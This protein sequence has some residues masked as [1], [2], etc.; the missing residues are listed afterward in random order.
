VQAALHIGDLLVYHEIRW[1]VEIVWKRSSA[2]SDTKQGRRQ[3]GRVHDLIFFYTKG[4][5]WTWNPLYTPYDQS[6]INAFYKHVEPETGRCYRLGD[7]TGP[8][9]AAKGN[10]KYEV[11]G[12]TRYWRYSKEKM[13]DL[14]R[15]GR[16]VQTSPGAVPAYKRY[17]DEMPGVPLQDV[18]T[19]IS[20][21]G[22]QAQERLGYPTQKPLS[23]FERI[24]QTSSDE[25]MVLLD[26]FV[27]AARRSTR[28]RSWAGAGSASTL[29]TSPSP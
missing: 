2:H 21:I 11:M 17:L 14:I 22:A 4:E 20:P 27:A 28:R 7:V 19:D 8:G 26:H 3:H 6:Y 24:I 16:I 12:V 1:N 13:E 29:P 15:Q 25:N 9:G 5:T 23:F 10:P 18:W